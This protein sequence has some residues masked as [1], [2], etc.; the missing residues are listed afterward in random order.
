MPGGR[1][2]ATAPLPTASVLG[3]VG[4]GSEQSHGRVRPTAPRPVLRAVAFREAHGAGWKIAAV[5]WLFRCASRRVLDAEGAVIAPRG[6]E[7]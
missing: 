2:I 5:R 4:L 1:R 3:K 7:E 6:D